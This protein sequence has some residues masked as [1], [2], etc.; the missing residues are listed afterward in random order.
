MHVCLWCGQLNLVVV[1]VTIAEIRQPKLSNVSIG[2]LWQ[3]LH[4]AQLWQSNSRSRRPASACGWNGNFLNWRLVSKEGT[5]LLIISLDFLYASDKRF[6]PPP[7][8][9]ARVASI[10][11]CSSC[12]I[13]CEGKA[14]SSATT[15]TSGNC[16][17]QEDL[18]PGFPN[19]CS[20][21]GILH[22]VQ[23]WVLPMINRDKNYTR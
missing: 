10:V 8:R 20:E 1:R 2:L 3:V 23:R 21:S 12:S 9:E 7:S 16:S 11:L 13:G 5:Q 17:A 14:V 4:C 22:P 6:L 15:E 18:F 19:A